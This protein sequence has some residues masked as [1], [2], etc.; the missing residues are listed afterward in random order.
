M[1]FTQ[2][3]GGG[4][5]RSTKG[6]TVTPRLAVSAMT[7]SRAGRGWSVMGGVVREVLAS[8]GWSEKGSLHFSRD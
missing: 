4:R 5:E 6:M 7:R 2:L 1:E 8:L 3:L